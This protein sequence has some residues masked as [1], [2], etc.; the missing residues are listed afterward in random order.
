LSIVIFIFHESH[1][2]SMNHTHTHTWTHAC[3][4]TCTH[5]RM[6]AQTHTQTYTHTNTQTHTQGVGYW[7]NLYN[8]PPIWTA[9]QN[10]FIGELSLIQVGDQ[11]LVNWKA[12]LLQL[13][14]WLILKLGLKIER[15]GANLL[16][17]KSSYFG[18]A[19]L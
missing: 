6:H 1:H 2:E 15:L 9:V 16:H 12:K 10:H 14:E 19:F 3:T 4:H 13:Q 5:T 8:Q 17:I 7:N 11:Y 18:I